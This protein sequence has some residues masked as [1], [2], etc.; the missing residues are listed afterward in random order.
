MTQHLTSLVDDAEW[1]RHF[2]CDD[3]L[4]I[5]MIDRLRK[6][7]DRIESLN[8]EVMRLTKA[9]EQIA[10]TPNAG[11]MIARASLQERGG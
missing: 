8:S 7:A 9:L 6:A 4:N 3:K 11:W 10:E 5:W 1:L 2:E